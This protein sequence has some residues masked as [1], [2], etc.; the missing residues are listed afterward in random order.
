MRCIVTGDQLGEH[1]SQGRA[2]HEH[3]V[4]VDLRRCCAHCSEVDVVRTR[5]SAKGLLHEHA[6][7]PGVQ[8]AIDLVE[9]EPLIELDVFCHQL[10]RVQL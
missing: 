4:T 8:S 9:A 1:A 3:M 6:P 5:S 10:V 2:F 7:E